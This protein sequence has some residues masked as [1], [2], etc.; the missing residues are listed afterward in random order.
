MVARAAGVSPSTVSRILNGTAKVSADKKQAV[1]EAIAQLGFHPNPVARSLAGG[2]SL[3]IGVLTQSIG[4]PFYGAASIGI[5]DELGAAGYV[6]IFVSGHWNPQDEERSLN[7][8]VSRRIDGL[9]IFAG[10]LPDA[11]LQA[12]SERVPTVITGR[13]VEGPR[14]L[15]LNFD[16]VEGARLATRHLIDLGHRR[17]AHITGDLAHAD[18]VEREQGYRLA[19][20]EAGIA[21]DPALVV[22]GDFIEASGLRAVHQL[23][24]TRHD[25]SAIF[26]AN[27]QMALGAM[28]GLFRRGL[29]VP[30]DVSVVGFDDVQGSSY[31]IPPLTTV[32]VPVYELG[33]LASQAVLGLLRGV[34]LSLDVPAPR[35]QLR[36]S[37]RRMR[38]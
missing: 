30:D 33:C 15:N 21:F 9:I 11:S 37:T 23:I 5:E 38:A 14:L 8:L 24:D 28:L 2:R 10:G 19:L 29:R 6:P 1:D 27:D 26:C 20:S 7:M 31:T 3:S 35:L 25:F 32:H 18:A 12:L 16:N 17:I 34:R 4:S 36:E 13:T 22:N